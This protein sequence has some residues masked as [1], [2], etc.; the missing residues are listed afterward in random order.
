MVRE[1][2]GLLDEVNGGLYVVPPLHYVRTGDVV[3]DEVH[4]ADERGPGHAQGTEDGVP[5][6]HDATSSELRSCPL[7]SCVVW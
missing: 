1:G 6:L 7:Q 4:F 5:H 3:S 2:G